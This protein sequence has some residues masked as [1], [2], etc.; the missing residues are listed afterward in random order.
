[1][2]VWLVFTTLTLKVWG[3]D[4]CFS[5]T[6][7]RSKNQAR[8]IFTGLTDFYW[9]CSGHKVRLNGIVKKPSLLKGGSSAIYFLHLPLQS[10]FEKSCVS[11][12]QSM[13]FFLP[14]SSNSNIPKTSF[15]GMTFLNKLYNLCIF[16]DAKNLQ[17]LA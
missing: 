3:D 15:M 8:M 9:P 6:R 12:Q 10:T 14:E 11:S 16:I 13:N 2:F 17:D 1:M 4:H 5:A 7:K